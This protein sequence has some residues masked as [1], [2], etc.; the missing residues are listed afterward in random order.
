MWQNYILF[1][2]LYGIT[3][4]IHTFIKDT[5]LM[6]QNEREAAAKREKLIKRKQREAD[7]AEQKETQKASPKSRKKKNKKTI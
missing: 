1:N 7:K 4:K 6:A 3:M 5:K 2:D